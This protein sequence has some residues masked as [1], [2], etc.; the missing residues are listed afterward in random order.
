MDHLLFW[1]LDL[2]LHFVLYKY[3]IINRVRS[4]QIEVL[5]RTVRQVPTEI[6]DHIAFVS[7]HSLYGQLWSPYQR[8]SNCPISFRS[9]LPQVYTFDLYIVQILQPNWAEPI[10]GVLRYEPYIQWNIHNIC[11][12][13]TVFF[14]FSD[15]L[16][17]HGLF[18]DQSEKRKLTSGTL[19]QQI[20]SAPCSRNTEWTKSRFINFVEPELALNWNN[21]FGLVEMPNNLW[22]DLWICLILETNP[23]PLLNILKIKNIPIILSWRI[24]DSYWLMRF[25]VFPFRWEK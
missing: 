16:I 13:L 11:V 14:M 4:H 15:W 21:V 25:V 2:T 23:N 9:L 1:N 19:I 7:L 22:L 6:L 5:S 12:P 18:M 17:D 24:L 3:P 20:S 10:V 8:K